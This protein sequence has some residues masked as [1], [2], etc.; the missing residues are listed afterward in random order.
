MTR[1]AHGP[2]GYQSRGTLDRRPGV[3]WRTLVIAT[4]GLW[5]DM[6]RKPARVQP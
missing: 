2:Q 1:P 3:V 5:Y 6:S 4:D